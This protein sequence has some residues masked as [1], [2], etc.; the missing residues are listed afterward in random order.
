[1]ALFDQREANAMHSLP[2]PSSLFLPLRHFRVFSGYFHLPRKALS[3]RALAWMRATRLALAITRGVAERPPGI[4]EA[5]RVM[6][7][8]GHKTDARPLPLLPSLAPF[9]AS[10]LM[11]KTEYG[12]GLVDL[13][14]EARLG[15]SCG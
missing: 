3:R 1:M 5:E 4:S 11:E 8:K 14:R 2:S 12:H 13:H 6:R 9:P 10:S 7:G 15:S